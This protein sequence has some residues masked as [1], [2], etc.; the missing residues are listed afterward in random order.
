MM[1]LSGSQDASDLHH[2]TKQAT[3][4]F[5]SPDIHVILEHVMFTLI[6]C[7]VREPEHHLPFKTVQNNDPLPTNWDTAESI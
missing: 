3:I 4:G 1:V 6:S 2:C 5:K 7:S